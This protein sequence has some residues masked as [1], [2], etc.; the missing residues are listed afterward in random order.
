MRR[1][2][3][4]TEARNGIHAAGAAAVLRAHRLLT[5]RVEAALAPLGLNMA[6]YEVLGLLNARPDGQMG[7]TDLKRVTLLHAATMGHNVRR[8]EAAGLI[9]RRRDATD[10]RALVA[11]I[12]AEGRRLA[13]RATAALAGIRF[14][15]ADLSP[16]RT[17]ALRDVLEEL[18]P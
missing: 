3:A 16:D 2:Q 1:S 7:F 11:E 12:T 5:S 18:Q 9:R 15:L 6:R 10:G 13:D 4:I 14:G 17:A 8:L